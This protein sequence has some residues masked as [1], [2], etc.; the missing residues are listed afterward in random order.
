MFEKSRE[1]VAELESSGYAEDEMPYCVLMDGLAKAGQ[2][3]E[4]KVIFDKMMKKQVRYDGYAHS[5]MISAFCRAK[6]F[7]EAKQLA[8]DFQTTFNKYDVVIMN[9]MLCAFCRVGE[10]DSVVDY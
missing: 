1:L 9:S 2:I 8:K 5:I 4:A 6:I 3:H 7:Q 10:M